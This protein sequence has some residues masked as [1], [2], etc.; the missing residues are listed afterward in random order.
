MSSHRQPEKSKWLHRGRLRDVVVVLCV[1][2]AF[3]FPLTTTARCVAFALLATGCSLH[4]LA[5]GQLIRNVT[6]CTE[7]AYAIVRHPYY[8][9]NYLIDA[10]FCLLSGNVYLMFLYPFLFFWAYG[11]TLR[12]EAARLASLHAEAFDAYRETVPEVFPDRAS[13][14]RLAAL[15]R[16]FSCRRVSSGEIKR[17][18]RFGFIGTLIALVQD[19]GVQGLQEIVAGRNPVHGGGVV[20]LALCILFLLASASIPRRR[21]KI[22]H[23]DGSQDDD[24]L[25]RSP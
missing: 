3:S 22:N 4:L 15:F 2:S 11:S 21:E 20:L 14:T 8:L 9:A 6:L 18:L 10:S 7:G 16:R 1:A 13:L 24:S 17:V 5:K 23:A 12:E 19:V 25:K